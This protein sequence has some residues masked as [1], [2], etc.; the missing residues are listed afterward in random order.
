MD[1]KAGEEIAAP[2]LAAISLVSQLDS[3]NKDGFSFHEK[4]DPVFADSET[5][6]RGGQIHQ[7][8]GARQRLGE[9]RVA[10]Q[11]SS[12]AFLDFWREFYEVFFPAGSKFYFV[13]MGYAEAISERILE[14]GTQPLRLASSIARLRELTNFWSKGILDSML[15]ISQPAGLV[16][17]EWYSSSVSLSSKA[18]SI[19][20][21][22]SRNAAVSKTNNFGV[23]SLSRY[24]AAWDFLPSF[25]LASGFTLLQATSLPFKFL[26]ERPN[27]I[28]FLFVILENSV[29]EEVLPVN[30]SEENVKDAVSQKL[31]IY[32]T[33]AGEV[34]CRL[35]APRFDAAQWTNNSDSESE[36]FV[37][38]E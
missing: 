20:E 30:K 33:A 5:M 29:A 31:T 2:N 19:A 24:R 34:S 11:F 7:G 28:K 12:D 32:G 35:A 3:F 37:I 36:G 13:Q 17:G 4:G 27:A 25:R 15:S 26:G 6:R 23:P 38:G 1:I 22:I 21:R 8:L 10:L 9:L 16:L 14:K 18:S